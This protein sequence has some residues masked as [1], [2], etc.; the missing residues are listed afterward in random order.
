MKRNFSRALS[1]LAVTGALV[2]SLGGLGAAA[3]AL[4]AK[5]LRAEFA[6][7]QT[8]AKPLRAE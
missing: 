4:N 3:A 5:P 2:V 8:V 7:V 6:P 1:A